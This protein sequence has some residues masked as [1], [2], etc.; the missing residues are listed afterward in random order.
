M[1]TQ[2]TKKFRSIRVVTT[3]DVETGE[4]TTEKYFLPIEES[5][6]PIAPS[7]PATR[8]DMPPSYQ[9]ASTTLPSPHSP[10]PS[11]PRCPPA[12]R[13][14]KRSREETPPSIELPP[15]SQEI[16]EIS[17]SSDSENEDEAECTR[18]CVVCKNYAYFKGGNVCEACCVKQLGP[19]EEIIK[20]FDAGT[21][22]GIQGLDLIPCKGCNDMAL[23]GAKDGLCSDCQP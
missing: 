11:S 23:A 22:A 7:T 13:L 21:Q 5:A 2:P 1:S 14:G 19:Y 20:K 18:F 16:I 3:I 17:D 9:T 15:P 8:I 10:L 6:S 4:T 12:P